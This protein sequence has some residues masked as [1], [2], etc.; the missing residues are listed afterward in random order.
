LHLNHVSKSKTMVRTFGVLLVSILLGGSAAAQQFDSQAEQRFVEL[1]NRERERAGVPSLKVDERLVKA[2]REHSA[3]MAQAKTLSHQIGGEPR[4][5]NRL[6]ATGIRF[7]SDAE[8][9][10]YDSEVESAHTGFM[11]SPG[12]RE[13]ILSPKYNT[14][15]VG[16]VRSGDV[17]W[18][19][20]DFANRLQEYSAD[21]AE[22]TIIAAWQ[23]E[24]RRS[25]NRP[26]AVGRVPQ[27][28]PMACAM[29]NREELNTRSLLRLPDVQAAVA[30]T[31]S[32]P[33]KLPS[34]AVKKAHDP[35]VRRIA[36]GACFA[37]GPKYSAGVW[38]VCM[39]F[40]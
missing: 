29:G 7:N 32:D 16:V 36:V 28:R 33:A 31:E 11:H 23:G 4:L 21:E 15:G 19:T 6:A 40:Y 12:H 27:L 26:A 22:Q 34:N 18:V 38:W 30:Y 25:R 37:D 24:R 9:V 17:L 3:R 1:I 2:A 10:A 8:N 13:N 39:V 35:N 5:S 14:V 20:E